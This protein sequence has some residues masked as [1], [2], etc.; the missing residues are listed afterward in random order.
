MLKRFAI[1]NLFVW[2][3]WQM[4]T[5]AERTKSIHFCFALHFMCC[6]AHTIRLCFEIG[7]INK[8][9]LSER[10]ESR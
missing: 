9:S 10:N 4:Q 3:K 1:I 8:L 7:R 2:I 6:G 5:K